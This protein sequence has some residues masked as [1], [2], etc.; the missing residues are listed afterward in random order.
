MHCIDKKQHSPAIHAAYGELL[1]PVFGFI[2]IITSSPRAL[3]Q[4]L[5]IGGSVRRMQR[6]SSVAFQ[7]CADTY[8]P[9]ISGAK[10]ADRSPAAFL[11]AV[12]L[13]SMSP[14]IDIIEMRAAVPAN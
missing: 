3:P 12:Q 4:K 2:S 9:G 6:R 14:E 11:V 7:I 5:R 1:F 10:Q 8:D 13:Y